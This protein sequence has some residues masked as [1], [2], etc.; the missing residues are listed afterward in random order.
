MKKEYILFIDSGVGGLSTLAETMKLVHA[1]FIYF[2]DNLHSPYGS[3]SDSE[4]FEYLK[5]IIEDLQ[6]KYELS[7]VVLACNTATTSS[8]KNLRAYFKNITFVGTEPAIKLACDNGAKSILCL[9]TPTTA[10]QVRYLHLKDEASAAV[11][12]L[13]VPTL[14]MDIENFLLNNNLK[15]SLTLKKRLFAVASKSKSFDAIVLGCT[16]YIFV[17]KHIKDL[18]F[19]PIYDGNFGVA[20]QIS[21]IKHKNTPKS[22][23][24]FM[25]SMDNKTLKQKYKKIL[26][27]ILANQKNLC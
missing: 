3:H 4:I 20:K 16:H 25:F 7:V 2:A 24:K 26:G 12:T 22:T 27:Q 11:D 21:N 23:V 10:R 1:N 6:K 5:K 8:I 19:L 9:A 14:A 18:T 15:Y 17:K 13:S